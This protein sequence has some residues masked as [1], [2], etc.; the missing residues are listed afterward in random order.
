MHLAM[1]MMLARGATVLK[2]GMTSQI[3]GDAK[4]SETIPVWA[5]NLAKDL[6]W[7]DAKA[8]PKAEYR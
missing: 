7:V 6:G 8:E 5:V 1:Q 3:P 2:R 4:G